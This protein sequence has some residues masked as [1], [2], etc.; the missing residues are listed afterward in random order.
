MTTYV[1]I[2]PGGH[3]GAHMYKRAQ[4]THIIMYRYDIQFSHSGENTVPGDR[5][6]LHKETIN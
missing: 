6:M 5:A 3:S 2:S 1:P 4:T